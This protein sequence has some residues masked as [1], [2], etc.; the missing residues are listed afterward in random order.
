MKT[1][2]IDW[3]CDADP[4]SDQ[5]TKRVYF[6]PKMDLSKFWIWTGTLLRNLM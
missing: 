3:N 2:S 6:F 4:V 1:V 5:L